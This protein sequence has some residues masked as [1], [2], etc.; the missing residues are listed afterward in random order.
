MESKIDLYTNFY[1]EDVDGFIKIGNELC[2]DLD[3][4]CFTKYCRNLINFLI[5]NTLFNYL[6]N[7][8]S[9][10]NSEILKNYSEYKIYVVEIIT[11]NNILLEMVKN[12]RFEIEKFSKFN[13]KFKILNDYILF[14]KNLDNKEYYKNLY[15]VGSNN[16]DRIY[17]NLVV[18]KDT[19]KKCNSKDVI[20]NIDLYN[21]F[22]C[23]SNKL[24]KYYKLRKNFNNV[25]KIESI[26]ENNKNLNKSINDILLMMEEIE[27]IKPYTKNLTL[28]QSKNDND[29]KLPLILGTGITLILA[30][31]LKLAN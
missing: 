13:S 3:K 25:I 24:I 18:T 16:I 5:N 12:N 4:V 9:D 6:I 19:I 30:I 11:L 8:L 29:F 27:E 26:K 15:C 20:Y 10:V 14:L 17:I 1:K 2:I 22:I 7:F 21:N 31:S 28:V 23:L